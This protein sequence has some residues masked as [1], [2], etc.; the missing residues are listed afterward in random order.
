MKSKVVIVICTVI[1]VLSVSL[2]ALA[3]TVSAKGYERFTV[4]DKLDY[5]E[6][7]E[8]ENMAKQKKLCLAK[9]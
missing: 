4:K 3:V 1:A 8:R 9:D 6:V 5:S 2:V 7:A